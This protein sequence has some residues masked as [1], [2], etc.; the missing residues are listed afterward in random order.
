MCLL[1]GG[2]ICPG[3][4]LTPPEELLPYPQMRLGTWSLGGPCSKLPLFKASITVA[5]LEWAD[6]DGACRG[7]VACRGVMWPGV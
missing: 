3:F 2:S 1:T 4:H 6:I 7:G 5:V